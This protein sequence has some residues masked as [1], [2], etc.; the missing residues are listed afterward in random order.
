LPSRLRC[1]AAFCCS[2]LKP[3]GHFR[4]VVKRSFHLRRWIFIQR[5][6]ITH[7]YSIYLCTPL[8][9]AARVV[10]VVETLGSFSHD[11]DNQFLIRRIF[12]LAW[13][14]PHSSKLSYSSC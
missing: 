7:S 14:I 10:P 2:L 11:L 9:W 13:K 1:F 4:C 8:H 12:L 3:L 5:M 6:K